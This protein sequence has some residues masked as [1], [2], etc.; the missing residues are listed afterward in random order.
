MEANT[1]IIFSKA[2][3]SKRI[4]SSKIPKNTHI[5][6]HFSFASAFSMV[7]SGLVRSYI[8]LFI[9]YCCTGGTLWHLQKFLQY[10]IVEFN[11]SI[12]LLYSPTPHSW[13]S[14][15]RSHFSIFIHVYI[16]PP[17]SPSYKLPLTTGTNSQTWPVLPSYS[18]FL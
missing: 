18:P 3:S 12:I 6:T 17:Y 16:F 1:S 4:R 7:W 15:N 9:Y 10:I 11:P 5:D 8:Y 2:T 13:N 14:F